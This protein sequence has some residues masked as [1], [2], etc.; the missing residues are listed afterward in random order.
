M[1]GMLNKELRFGTKKHKQICK[2]IWDRKEVSAS[3]MSEFHERW[4][5]VDENMQAYI[6]ESDADALRRNRKRYEGKL[7][8]VTLEVPYQFAV[9]SSMHT[10]I[11]SVFLSRAPVFQFSARH[12]ETQNQILAVEAVMDYQLSVG[13]MLPYIYNWL[14]DGC[15]YGFGVIGE[16]WDS[17]VKIISEFVE[18]EKKV[19]GIF[20]SG[21]MEKVRRVTEIP[22]YQGNKL[23]MIRT[24]DFFPDPRLPLFDFQRGEFCGRRVRVGFSELRDGARQG[25]YFNLE[26]LEKTKGKKEEIDKI[27]GSWAP[28][29]DDTGSRVLVQPDGVEDIDMSAPGRQFV[30]LIE[31]CIKI[32]PKAW[33]LGDSSA[34][35][36]WMF[37]LANERVVIGARPLGYYHNKFPYSILETGFGEEFI[38]LS[39]TEMIR[40]LTEALTWL[41]NTHMY[42]VRKAI[43][44]VRVV[45]PSKVVMKDLAQPQPGGIIRLKPQFYGG[46][47]RTAVTQLNVNDVT[48]GHLRD[49]QIVEQLIQRTSGVVDNIMGLVSQGGRKTATEVR[50]SSGFSINRIKTLAEYFSATGFSPLAS[51]MLSNTQQ[52]LDV[53]RKYAIA[54]N[55]LQGAEQFVDVNPESLAGFF[56]F[57]P[58]DGTLPVDRLAQANF[59]KELL[60]QLARIPQLAQQW[61]FG[62]MIA[63]TMALQGERNVNRFKI[64]VQQPG[65][66]Q[67]QAQAGNVVPLSEVAGGAGLGRATGTSGGTL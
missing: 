12:G 1:A 5:E 53:E 11:T 36:I 64:Q 56:D 41:F 62:E 15:K 66:V 63:Y 65:M 37:T 54:G 52:L 16:Y 30:D 48:V 24:R 6:P 10:Y 60:V 38:K 9:I 55:T 43:N 7:D 45:D 4:S 46:D 58:V 33:G 3:K 49:A 47:T 39:T 42:N 17:E 18:Q 61:D 32:S 14:W 19:L 13:N 22:G 51:R 59:W 57:V 25:R 29:G 44:D 31:M 26:V 2:A 28:T 23:Y 34:T 20:G 40:P 8:Y 50:T 21:N 27:E 35:E 67:Q